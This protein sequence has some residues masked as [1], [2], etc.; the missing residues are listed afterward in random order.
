M[1][2]YHLLF[3]V[4]PLNL[5]SQVF[6]NEASNVNVSTLVLPNGSD[7]DWIELYNAAN[8]NINMVGYFLS[9]DSTNLQKWTFPNLNL[10]PNGFV[11]I[12]A[13]G[14]LNQSTNYFYET[15]VFATNTWKYIIPNSNLASDWNNL[16]FDASAW[17]SGQ[18]SVGYGDDDDETEISNPST[19]VYALI[20][21]SISDTSKIKKALLD[22]DFDD[23]FVAYLNGIEI[24]RVGLTGT[25]PNW[26]ELATDHEASLILGG[27]ISSF[28]I[29]PMILKSAMKNGQNV[30]AIEVHN[31]STT[32]SD[33]TMLPFL[34]FGYETPNSFYG[35]NVHAYFNTVFSNSILE[36]NF[37]ISNEGEVIYLSNPL[38]I[39]IDSLIVPD[40]EPN[41]SVGKFLDGVQNDKLFTL[42][43][44]GQ[45]NNL[46]L[47][48]EAFENAPIIKTD[49]QFFQDSL[50]IIVTNNSVFSG[51]VFYTLNGET[52]TISSNLYVDTI[53]IYNNTILKVK[54]FAPADSILPSLMATESYLLAVDYA[55]PVISIT[56]DSLNLYGPDGI[57]DNYNTDWKKPC[58]IEYFDKDGIKQFESRASI[59]PDGGAGGSRSNPQHSV[60]I[61]PANLLYGEGKSV[62][63]PLIPEK[64]FI[65]EFDAFYLRNGSN[66]WNQYPQK[67]A[68][69]MRMMRE[70]NANSQAYSP[71]IAYVNGEYFGVYELR[72]KANEGYFATNYGN[73]RDSLDLLSVSYF[74]GA[75][76][77]RTV[78]GSDSSFYTM[79]DL[80]TTYDPAASDYFSVCNKKLDLYN[81]TDYLVGENWFA[82]YDWVYNN[83]KIA[84]TQS[85]DNKWKFFLQDMELGLGGW[86]DFNSNIFDYF[87][88]NNQPNPY[89]E[90]FNGL[91]QNTEFKNYFVNRY[92]DLM[93]TTFQPDYYLPIVE[94][95]YQQL[96]PDLP[97]HFERWT[98][99]PTGG[100]NNYL[101][102]KNN[103]LYQF[104]NRN[105]VVRNQIVNEFALVKPVTVYLNV[106]PAEAGYIKISTIVPNQ[107]PWTGVYFDGVPVEVTAVANPGYTFNHWKA[108]TTLEAQQLDSANF[109]I[110]IGNDDSFIA[111][112]NGISEPLSLTLSEIN[113]NPDPSVD[114]GNWIELHNFGSTPLNLTNWSIKSKNFWDKY[115]FEDGV[116][117]PSDG[118]LVICEDTNLFKNTY[119]NV[120]NFVGATGFQWSNKFDSI[121][122]YDAH[123]KLVINTIYTDEKPFPICADGWGRTLENQYLNSVKIDSSNWFCGCIGGSPGAKY[124]PCNEQLLISE[125]NYNNI[126]AVYNAGDWIEIKNNSNQSLDLLN[127]IFKD[128]KNN[129]IYNFPSI[130]LKPNEYLVLTNNKELFQKRHPEVEN[131][132]GSF[133]FGL[134]GKEFLRLFDASETLI[135][136]VIYRND[137]NWPA[138][139]SLEDFTLEYNFS[140][141]FVDPNVPTSWFAGCEGGSPGRAFENCPV[142]TDG[143]FCNI[144]PNPTNGTFTIAFQ[145]ENNS[146]NKTKI[147]IIDMNGRLIFEEEIYAIEST[148]GKDINLDFP[149][150]GMYFVKVIQ[151]SKT[152]QLPLV[153][154]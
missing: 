76:I 10:A 65:K 74:Y 120:D 15:A 121:Q 110:N 102:I 1:K 134:S 37:G 45:S 118:Y 26:D 149:R 19:S 31:S 126:S 18:M 3:L 130:E 79:K 131:V 96:L 17:N 78:K 87:R 25:P 50:K 91:N 151:E 116:S 21:F 47:A 81:F 80:I 95:M 64:S 143:D 133:D 56:T 36:T 144:Y 109:T 55:L 75:G 13:T 60:T 132:I 154:I 66:Y 38:G 4:F 94:S 114:G 101:N 23:G 27:N 5:F 128:S 142:L 111:V 82:N 11:T 138:I 103:L 98:G 14:N 12:A 40:L 108:N 71:V 84:R 90:I 97:K 152:Q 106:E 85:T 105:Q 150:A 8:S 86:S 35:G 72:E 59:K 127:F 24:A 140:N 68:T 137:N 6:L 44:P 62:K 88:N 39:V 7:P 67:D 119:P 146:S 34:S 41:M 136:S 49:G 107:L 125:I 61:E 73:D 29:D 70:T 9:D 20:N 112:F 135:A 145:N 141:G 48:Y 124:T 51:Q 58:V 99:D 113:Y 93:N 100:M 148:V 139:P 46:S 129:N 32:S 115:A 54:C 52:P 83:I 28:E 30:L 89:W 53:T 69:F 104:S 2:I 43:T 77:L 63:Y 92:A 16:S 117:I 33:L 57:F 147:Q 22:L 123:K 122:V 153:K 42:P